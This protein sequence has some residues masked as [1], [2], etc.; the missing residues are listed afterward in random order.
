MTDQPTPYRD[1]AGTYRAAGW[2]GVLPIPYRSKKMRKEGWTGHA[3]DWPSAADIEAWCE[4]DRTDEGGGN[5]ALRLPPDVIGVDVDNYGDKRGGADLV[6]VVERWGELPPT[7]KSTPS[8]LK[9]TA[10]TVEPLFE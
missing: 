4:T 6:A 1:A 2:V 9:F 8:G 5:I 7:W 3:G 10:V